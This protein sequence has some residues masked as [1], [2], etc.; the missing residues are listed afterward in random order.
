MWALFGL[1]LV[2]CKAVRIEASTRARVSR[3]AS[4]KVC[5]E[6]GVLPERVGTYRGDMVNGDTPAPLSDR[7]VLKG[8]KV[9]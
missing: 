4:H 7:G 3:R 2:W 5:G 9:G 8:R 6:R 1:T